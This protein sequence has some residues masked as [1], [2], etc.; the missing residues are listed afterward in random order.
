[1][2]PAEIP[3]TLEGPPPQIISMA[4]LFDGFFSIDWIQALSGAKATE[5]LVLC[6]Q[7]AG[8]GI[9]QKGETGFYCFSDEAVKGNI[10]DFIPIEQRQTLHK[11]IAK[12]LASEVLESDQAFMAGAK[13]L[14]HVENDYE[15]CEILKKAGDVLRREG[16]STQAM[17]YYDKVIND[18]K[19]LSGREVD[20]L[21]AEVAIAFSKDSAA[22]GHSNK[23][24]SYLQQALGRLEQRG[25]SQALTALVLFHLASNEYIIGNIDV[26]L[27]YRAAGLEKAKG[28]N[29]PK[30]ERTLFTSKVVYLVE[31]GQHTKAIETYEAGE[32]LFTKKHPKHK[33][34]MKMIHMMGVSYALTGQ[35]SQ[36]LGMLDGLHDH[37]LKIGDYDT[38]ATAL[39]HIGLILTMTA[40]YENS[41]KHLKEALRLS[42]GVKQFVHCYGFGYLGFC[43]YKLG[44]N[45]A[46]HH[47][48]KRALDIV[49]KHQYYLGAFLL[50]FCL[51]MEKGNY[52]AIKGISL[53]NEIEKALKVE[54][55]NHRGQ[56]YHFLALYQKS[57]G[58]D[59]ETILSNLY[60]ALELI[61]ECG[62]IQAA[63]WIKVEIARQMLAQ[64]H[65]EQ[66]RTMAREASAVLY[67]FGR[68]KVPGD[69]RHLTEGL[70]INDDITK[71]ILSLGRELVAKR[72]TKEIVNQILSTVNKITGAE[73]AGIFRSRAKDG[74]K[75]FELWAAK[76][77]LIEDIEQPDFAH[78][79]H[80]IRQ[81]ADAGKGFL[82]N[83]DSDDPF[84]YQQRGSIKSRICVPMSYRGKTIGVLYHDNR[85]FRSTFH[86]GDLDVLPYFASLAAIAL[87]N[88][89]AY[90]EIQRLNQRLHEEK[91]YLEEQQLEQLHF[92]DFVAA[93][94]PIKRV[95]TLV[96]RVAKTDSTVMILGETG[97]GKEMVARA[98][99]QQSQRRDNSFIRVHCSSLPE[100]LITSELFGH[101][102]GAFTGAIER[103][104]GRFELAD[105]G[106]LFLDEIG[107]I[108]MDIQ[109]R[110]LRV[111]QT[112]EFER[113]GGR[114]TIRSD[115]R[116]I[117]AT[118]RNLEEEV[119][120]GRF[121]SDLYYRLS[122]FPIYVPP[123]RE[124]I[125][126]IAPLA[127]H[128]LRIHSERMGKSFKGIP[129]MEMQKLLA[130]HW[131][132][133]VRELENVIERGVILNSGSLFVVPELG[134]HS[135]EAPSTGQLSLEEMER[136]YILDTLQK[137][138]WKVYGPGGAAE[139]LGLNHSTL[140]SRMK[141]LGI[142]KAEH[143]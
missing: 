122:V 137:T 30:V 84:G 133:N 63:A 45:Q 126:D 32:P 90:E 142:K 132:G 143:I 29:D 73:R 59:S 100:S 134:I 125:P 18:L 87:D 130:Y 141:K 96:E 114:E 44:D 81:A 103:R 34:S 33:L 10:R 55:Y 86:K 46:S 76:N 109:V 140:Y 117:V 67:Q 98:L 11:N 39:M 88:A 51:A 35:V 52:P 21:F 95:L 61:R 57:Q 58:L 4:S 106:T 116:L 102:K 79:L 12:L 42:K 78:S 89:W 65:Q 118:N 24:I 31:T 6:D 37:A 93:S 82:H 38:A 28:L 41:I 99:H 15:G 110:L 113:V 71:E 56:A 135:P 36:G 138:N 3:A 22:V 26:A 16:Q 127:N 19:G 107:E 13:H 40:D 14:M 64:G 60:K 43:H 120:A 7:Y 80:M 83:Q 47:Y 27:E 101:E 54:N 128:F 8:N 108:S 75:G 20:N 129:E 77:L 112:R 139:L 72:D 115:F 68:Q 136:R 70:A 50:E 23:I 111:L 62:N 123:L 92:D 74:K 97:V 105:G 119:A 85:L 104:V 48:L 53:K 66:A 49:E 131:P 25:G 9:F 17:A 121:R 91:L 69:L 2:Q 94:P 5:V 1:M 124:R